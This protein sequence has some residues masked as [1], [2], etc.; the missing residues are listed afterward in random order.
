MQKSNRLWVALATSGFLAMAPALVSAQGADGGTG[1]T[2]G[3]ASTGTGQ[4]RSFTGSSMGT[5]QGHR[6]TTPTE[7]DKRDM[8][9]N[10]RDN[11]R[12]QTSD[13]GTTSESNHRTPDSPSRMGGSLGSSQSPSGQSPVGQPPES[14]SG[15]S[16]AGQPPPSPSGQAMSPAG[17]SSTSR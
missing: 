2:S 15:Q 17:S 10:P 1:S 9:T 11:E 6:T 3:G 4:G 13:L 12:N 14:P 16:P 7:R 8:T 5:G